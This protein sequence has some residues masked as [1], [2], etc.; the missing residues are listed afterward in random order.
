MVDDHPK[1]TPAVRSSR[2][3][4]RRRLLVTSAV[5]SATALGGCSALSDSSSGDGFENVLEGDALADLTPSDVLPD[6]SSV[7]GGW[8]A[9]DVGTMSNTARRRYAPESSDPKGEDS[10]FAWAAVYD[11]LDYPSTRLA[12]HR[13]SATAGD[14]TEVGEAPYGDDALVADGDGETLLVA[15]ENNVF[16][17]YSS[18]A[19][20]GAQY[21]RTLA[22]STFRQ[23]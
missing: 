7:A 16:I 8:H 2:S 3:L 11:N 17:E 15:Y 22:D 21:V 12:Q 4:T 10:V 14:A 20:D 19:D 9:T 1:T 23:L 5:A 18:A 13:D 6:P